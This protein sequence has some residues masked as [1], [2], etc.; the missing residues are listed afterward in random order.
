MTPAQ[1][2][3]IMLLVDALRDADDEQAAG[4]VIHARRAAVEAALR[5]APQSEGWVL[6]PV[7]PTHNML[8]A[9]SGEWHPSRHDKARKQYAAMLAVAPRT[10]GQP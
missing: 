8:T 5:D 4:S 7:K 9:M 2:A 1:V 6:V 10:G 3:H